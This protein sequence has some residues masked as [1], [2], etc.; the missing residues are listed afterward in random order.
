[1]GL[2]SLFEE[3]KPRGLLEVVSPPPYEF[4]N[5]WQK[6]YNTIQPIT[7][8]M[9]DKVRDI[10]VPL[11]AQ[12]AIDK[13][14][15]IFGGDNGYPEWRLQKDLENIGKVE[16]DYVH[17]VAFN[18][19]PERSYWQVNPETARD[20]LVNAAVLFGKDFNKEFSKYGGYKGLLK[21]SISELQQ[22]LLDDDELAAAFAAVKVVQT[23]ED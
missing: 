17:K 18:N 4:W 22:L 6:Y 16:S 23:F 10:P 14:V 12:D 3:E 15:S 19:Q 1:M 2:L 7:Q 21:K 13:A 11:D 8:E 20:S 9:R 5:N